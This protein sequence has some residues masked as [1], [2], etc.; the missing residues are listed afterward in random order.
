MLNKLQIF[1]Q[2]LLPHHL[3]SR[4]IGW[5][6]NCRWPWVKNT[7]IKLFM[8]HYQVDLVLAEKS[9]PKQYANFN[10]FFTRA[11]RQGARP[12]V[13]DNDAIVSPVDGTVS[14]L[15]MIN[16]GTMIQAKGLDYQVQDLLGN[17]PW[18]TQ[19]GQ[20]QF[21]NLYLAP[22]DYHRVHIPVTGILRE[23]WYVPGKL[24]SV[25]PNTVAA[26]PNLFARN[27]RVICL[28]DTVNGPMAVV[29]VGAMIVASISTVWAGVVAPGRS[30]AIMHWEYAGQN[31]QYERGAEIGRF[32]LGSTVIVLFADNQLTWDR[33]LAPGTNVHLGQAVGHFHE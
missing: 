20:G 9:D 3:L 4:C 2:Y 17:A 7:F 18:A 8:W 14:Q 24:F 29:M 1:M 6:A 5:M 16:V 28:F 30:R 22:K 33:H 15:G 19:F 32:L 23:M 31:L 10:E 26:V 21:I 27:E 25:N 11:L 12:I 13:M